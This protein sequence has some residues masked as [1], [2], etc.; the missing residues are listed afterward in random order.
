[1]SS[2]LI[3]GEFQSDKY[4]TCPRGK[5]PLSVKDPTAQ[6]LLL[7]YAQRR[8]ALD[9]E[10]ADDLETALPGFGIDPQADQIAEEFMRRT[11]PLS[12]SLGSVTTAPRKLIADGL[13]HDERMT[14]GE[15]PAHVWYGSD[16]G[17]WVAICPHHEGEGDCDGPGDAA[18]VKAQIDASG[19]AWLRN[20]A[21]AILTGYAAALDEACRLR[22]DL[23][24][25]TCVEGDHLSKASRRMVETVMGDRDALRYRVRH[26][27]TGLLEACQTIESLAG[28][29]TLHSEVEDD[30]DYQIAQRL[31]AVLSESG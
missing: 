20:N 11:A 12:A 3:D 2:H 22:D 28:Q 23:D 4:P 30:D 21:R 19:I 8:R 10:F 29:H 1:M 7:E 24:H 26:L 15:W 14:P 13:K 17:G 9:A 18:E 16:R 25:A 6:D 5:V 31:R 27:E